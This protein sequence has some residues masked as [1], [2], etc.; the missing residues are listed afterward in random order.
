VPRTLSRPLVRAFPARRPRSYSWQVAQAG[1]VAY[2]A[3]KGGI[4]AVT[5]AL[6]IEFAPFDVRVNAVSPTVVDTPMT[7]DHIATTPDLDARYDVLLARQPMGRMASARDV[8]LAALFLA[9]DDAGFITGANI[10][11]DGGRHAA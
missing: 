3:S 11:V 5:R 7:H 8:A 2:T 9:S 10:P 6:A 4:V 1:T